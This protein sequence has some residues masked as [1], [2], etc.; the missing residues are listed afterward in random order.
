VVGID[1]GRGGGP[2]P[3]GY[4]RRREGRTGWEE[5]EELGAMAERVVAALLDLADRHAG[6]RVLVVTHGGPLRAALAAC[7]G[8]MRT[9]PAVGNGDIEEI[10]VRDGRMRLSEGFEGARRLDGTH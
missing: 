8:D 7:G 1:L 2:L 9:V 5:G 6:Q 4:R 10:A 3:D